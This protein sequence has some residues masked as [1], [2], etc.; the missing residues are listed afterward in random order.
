MHDP[1]GPCQACD[2]V[3]FCDLGEAL[4]CWTKGRPMRTRSGLALPTSSLRANTLCL[5]YRADSCLHPSNKNR[6]EICPETELTM[7]VLGFL[8]D[9]SLEVQIPITS[10]CLRTP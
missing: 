4:H 6:R 8:L 2:S 1:G 10:H 9:K 3:V 5:F 7:V